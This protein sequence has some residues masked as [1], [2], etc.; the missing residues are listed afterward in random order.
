MDRV[1]HGTAEFVLISSIPYPRF[2]IIQ[3][4]SQLTGSLDTF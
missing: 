1:I 3:T 2:F 4:S